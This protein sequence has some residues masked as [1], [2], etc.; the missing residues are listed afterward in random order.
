MSFSIG[1]INFKLIFVILVF[2]CIPLLIFGQIWY[3]K[4]TASIENNAVRYSQDLLKQTNEYLD[5]YMNDLEQASV[6]L[7]SKPQVQKYLD[8]KE[9]KS[10]RYERFIISKRIQE[11]A[12]AG[13]LDGRSEIFGISMINK[14]GMQVHNYIKADGYLNMGQIRDRNRKLWSEVNT[15][16]AYQVLDVTVIQETPVLTIVRKVFNENTYD[17]SGLLIINLRLDKIADIVN[18]VTSS[19]FN[20]VWIVNDQDKTI[21]HPNEKELGKTFSYAHKSAYHESNFFINRNESL[22]TLRVYDHSTQTNWTMVASVPLGSIIDSLITLRSSTMWIGLLLIGAALLFV[23]GF[24]FF[25]THSLTN[26]QKLMKKVESGNFAI[27][28]RKPLPFYRDDEVSD[29]YD[30]FYQMTEKLRHLIQEVKHSKVVEKELEL[31]NRESEFQA[32]Q[33]QINPHFLYNTLEI[34]NSHA[35]IENQPMIS[36]MTTSLADMFRYNVSN[37]KK[38]VTL[39]EELR[40]IQSYLEIQEER[41]DDLAVSI[42]CEEE[43]AGRVLMPRLTLQPV[44][45]NSFV[46][47]YEEHELNPEFIGIYGEHESHFYKLSIVDRGKGMPSET[48]NEL[49]DAFYYNH[50]LS[51]GNKTTKRIGLINVHKRLHGNFGP[52]YR[53]TVTQSD[54]KG[55]T[56]EIILPYAGH[57]QSEKEE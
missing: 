7:L 39:S 14:Q 16:E 30:S 40:Q 44:I 53:L 42:Q 54:E 56:V 10:S 26:L 36:K 6:P 13:I 48:K 52:P 34:I 38:I 1:S 37:S 31:K 51:D 23:G 9:E 43:T 33:S 29:L 17:T 5:F 11:D 25:L 20:D 28:R 35:I 2:V 12:F 24:S 57:V 27:E 41:F 50:D 46:H 21:Y 3:D 15:L 19:H 22:N 45:E 49:N 8:L 4:T 32:M 47:G 55:T 18:E